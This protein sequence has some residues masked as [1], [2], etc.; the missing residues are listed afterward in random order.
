M[1]WNVQ[2]SITAFITGSSVGPIRATVA[3]V[4]ETRLTSM[5]PMPHTLCEH[6][7][8]MSD[9]PLIYAGNTRTES[10]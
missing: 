8:F 3:R 1:W 4:L 2:T 7:R 5:N 9:L 10:T 6:S